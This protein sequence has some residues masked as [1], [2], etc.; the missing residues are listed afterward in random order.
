MSLW[1]ALTVKLSVLEL[2]AFIAE[3]V[4]NFEFLLTQESGRIRREACAIMTPTVKGEV[5]KGSQLPLRV[6]VASRE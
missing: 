4:N 2:H 1:L 3:V 6:V 5:E